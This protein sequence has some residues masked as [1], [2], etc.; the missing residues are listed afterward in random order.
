MRTVL[1]SALAIGFS[2][3]FAIGAFGQKIK[4]SVIAAENFYGDV[5]EQIGGDLVEV[6]SI[7]N[8]PNQDPHLFETTSTVVRQVSAAQVVIYNGADYDVWMENLLKAAPRERTVVVI[9]QLVNRKAGDNP[10]LWYVPSTMPD[11]CSRTR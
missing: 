10:H 8:N 6:A 2:L 5:A 3:A 9:A 1:Q 11:G 4:L 7:L